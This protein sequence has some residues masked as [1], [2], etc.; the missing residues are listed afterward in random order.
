MDIHVDGILD[1]YHSRKECIA[2]LIESMGPTTDYALIQELFLNLP[3]TEVVLG[4]SR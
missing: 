1:H 2:D 4:M 3:A